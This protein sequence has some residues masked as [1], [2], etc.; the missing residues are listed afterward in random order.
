[1]QS[2]LAIFAN[3]SKT[4]NINPFL[5]FKTMPTKG[6]PPDKPGQTGDPAETKPVQLTVPYSAIPTADRD[7]D[8]I[9]SAAPAPVAPELDQQLATTAGTSRDAVFTQLPRDHELSD[10]TPPLE[11]LLREIPR[12]RTV[13]RPR[14][15]ACCYMLFNI[16][17]PQTPEE[18]RRIEAEIHLLS[19]QPNYNIDLYDGW[20]LITGTAER[21]ANAL[22]STSES[23]RAAFPDSSVILGYGSIEH[24]GS[25]DY[26]IRGF[27]S[28]KVRG[29][30]KELGAGTYLTSE[31]VTVLADPNS[32]ENTHSEVTI[33]PYSPE[34]HTLDRYKAKV[35]TS[36]GGP[37]ELIGEEPTEN[38]N[39]L[40]GHFMDEDTKLIFLKG[41]AG[42]GKSRVLLEALAKY[43]VANVKCSLDA[44][45]VNLAGASL[46][47]IADQLATALSEDEMFQDGDSRIQR[48]SAMP[49]PAKIEFAQEN[50]AILAEI[51]IEALRQISFSKGPQTLLVIEDLHNSDR[52]SEQ[53]IEKIVNEYINPINP[54]TPAGGK[55]LISQ[56]PEEM[57]QSEAQRRMIG[58]IVRHFGNASI[59]EMVKTVTVKGL[60]FSKETNSHDFAFHMLPKEMRQGKRLARWHKEAGRA[61]GDSPFIMT[62]VIKGLLANPNTNFVMKG[63]IIDLSPQALENL[64]KIDPKSPDALNIYFHERIGNLDPKARK[65]LQCITLAGGKLSGKQIG[66]IIDSL[67]GGAVES[68]IEIRQALVDGAY[69]KEVAKAEEGENMWEL[70]HEML[71]PFVEGSI[72]PS[73]RSVMSEFLFNMVSED[74]DTHPDVK[75]SLLHNKSKDLPVS[76]E[77]TWATF[78]KTFNE[79]IQNARDHNARSKVFTIAQAI[80][81]KNRGIKAVMQVAQALTEIPEEGSTPLS[82]ELTELTITTLVEVAENGVWLGRF[83]EAEAASK[84]LHDIESLHPD[85]I[86]RERVVVF[87]FEAAYLQRKTKDMRAIYEDR[88]KNRAEIPRSTQVM[89]EI[90]LLFRDSK[91]AQ[92]QELYQQNEKALLD[93]DTKYRAQNGGRPNPE[94]IEVQR[95]AKLRNP[96]TQISHAVESKQYGDETLKVDQDIVLQR[97]A[98][99]SEQAAKIREMFVVLEEFKAI[100]EHHPTIF[101]PAA[102]VA[103]LEQEAHMH[104]LLG[105]TEVESER[106]HSETGISKMAEAWRQADQIG[107]HDSAA[108]TALFL[109][110]FYASRAVTINPFTQKVSHNRELL[111]KALQ[112]YERECRISTDELGETNDYNA[113]RRIQSVRATAL[114][115][116]SY[117]EELAQTLATDEDQGPERDLKI[118]AIRAQLE[119]HIKQGLANFT[120]INR[121]S[122]AQADQGAP[123]PMHQNDEYCYYLN[124]YFYPLLEMAGTLGIELPDAFQDISNLPFLSI[125][126]AHK[127]FNFGTGVSDLNLAGERARKMKNLASL[128]EFLQSYRDKQL[129]QSSQ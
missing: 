53:W 128:I 22:L 121:L 89:C 5:K 58:N 92:A 73:E 31:L 2:R 67:V 29:E 37:D 34:I 110:N 61:A 60:D 72:D 113:I 65:V 71:K 18:A 100:K 109:G 80:L 103:L 8:F 45:D 13:E 56:R 101:S 116:D 112:T 87:E 52:H 99:T 7:S 11:K 105:G 33:S 38:V 120:E 108:R 26:K 27:Q 36:I 51:C 119:A 85:L 79:S 32:R 96:L 76:D 28:P 126:A 10:H 50:A 54:D 64:G 102:E 95:L 47:T 19:K 81:D 74:S 25:S 129:A 21:S 24:Q 86:P 75:L 93:A 23:F 88:I 83:E 9:T 39:E 82:P 3:P 111:K 122:K 49:R 70:Q 90:K 46:I 16:S 118:A 55:V 69:I 12:P 4:A 78:L 59:D 117:Q 125:E 1:M 127:G 30:W 91:H 17:T 35:S 66:K 97:R 43:P 44:A 84:I 114:L 63:D 68:Q 15:G 41:E 123:T 94:I 57:Y 6:D 106:L 42:K 77:A 107:N 104:G 62:H 98:L 115:V 14:E 40:I 48:F 124:G 20:M